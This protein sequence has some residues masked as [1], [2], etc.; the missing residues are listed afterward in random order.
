MTKSALVV[1][2]NDYSV[3][4]ANNLSYCVNDANSMFHLLRHALDFEEENIILLRN[5]RATRRN[6]LSALTYLLSNA[7]PGDT[8]CFFYAGHGD[9]MPAT[10]N[11]DN[12]LYYEG[13]VPY[14]GESIMDLDLDTVIRNSGVDLTQ[15]NF[16]LILDSCHSGGIHP[17]DAI[18]QSIP[19]SVP[20]DPIVRQHIQ[21]IQTLWPIGICLPNGSD[22]ILMNV[23][24]ANLENNRLIDLDEDPNKTL[25]QSARA[26][27]IAA[28]KYYELAGE[29]STYQHGFLS[30][31]FLEI[32]N[33]SNF[34]MSYSDLMDR[35][36]TKVSAIS[37]NTQ[38]PQL[39]GQLG[40]AS[41][42]FLSGWR[43]SM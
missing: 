32:V 24:Q 12:T 31:A 40:R 35:L 17:T 14:K 10:S 11:A 34:Q 3:Q 38:T 28:C 2:I 15:I 8:V 41:E 4:G 7:Q 36:V 20:F 16:T 26:T 1:G 5:N 39:R 21:N 13:I 43:S 30:Q 42:H 25:V 18:E 9:I 29:S 33:S 27:L 37:G 19:R 23:N 22:Q 6:I